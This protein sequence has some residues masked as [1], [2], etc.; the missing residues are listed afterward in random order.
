MVDRQRTLTLTPF[1]G[2]DTWSIRG[3]IWAGEWSRVS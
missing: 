2:G 3:F 1:V